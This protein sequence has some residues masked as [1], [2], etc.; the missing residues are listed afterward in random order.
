MNNT[1]KIIGTHTKILEKGLKEK[2]SFKEIVKDI[3]LSAYP[4][5]FRGLNSPSA[6]LCGAYLYKA[7][8]GKAN[9]S[10]ANLG[11]AN[12]KKANLSGAD[13]SGATLSDAKLN[14]AYL[15]N[16]DL[17]GSNLNHADLNDADLSGANLSGANLGDALVGRSDLKAAL[18]FFIL[19]NIDTSNSPLKE[20]LIKI[21]SEG[22]GE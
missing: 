13:L 18:E 16:A 20:T 17:S 11:D 1:K 6:Y 9:L 12:L 22:K 3:E 10:C 8:L 5:D 14:H 21:L 15:K 19:N 7:N 4:R 2:K